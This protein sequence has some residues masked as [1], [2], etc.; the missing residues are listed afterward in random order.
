MFIEGRILTD[1]RETM[2]RGASSQRSVL[3]GHR[4]VAQTVGKGIV[5]GQRRLGAIG[6]CEAARGCAVVVRCSTGWHEARGS[7][8]HSTSLDCGLE[9]GRVRGGVKIKWLWER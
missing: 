8:W 4:Q 9:W 1:G 3:G 5:I 6:S 2:V 7:C